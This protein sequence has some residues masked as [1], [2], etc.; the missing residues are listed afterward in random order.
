MCFNQRG[1][2]SKQNSSSLKLVDKFTYLE[3]RVSS[4]ERDINTWLPKA[5]TAIDRLLVIWKTD[6]TD[7]MK[8]SFSQATV[9]SI[10]PHGCTTRTLTKRMEK[11][12]WRQLY[13]NAA[14][15]MEQV[16]E[17]AP[18]KS[19]AVR[20]LTIENY[21]S[22]TNQTYVTLREKLGWTHKW[23]T[24][25]DPFTCSSKGRMTISNLHTTA[26]CRY[27][28]GP[29]RPTGN[30]GQWIRVSGEGQVHY[31]W[32]DDDDDIYIYIYIYIYI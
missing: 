2:I 1:N 12:T 8:R 7:E 28:I 11:K 24:P 10:L 19:V 14:S 32:H 23:C 22:S 31:C 29:R 21:P 3:S 25:L 16:L 6:L 17:A 27:G 4:T 13:K 5:W 18:H 15:N 30:D 26:L 9:V 20:L